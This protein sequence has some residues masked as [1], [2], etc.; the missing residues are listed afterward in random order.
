MSQHKKILKEAQSVLSVL[1]HAKDDDG[2]RLDV[3]M[4]EIYLTDKNTGD[5]LELEIGLDEEKTKKKGNGRTY[6]KS[7][8]KSELAAEEL[9]VIY[10]E[11]GV[12]GEPVE[13][14]W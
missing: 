5:V 8:H 3:C 1:K 10:D 7:V 6:Y 11:R 9:E 2:N 14:R 13:Y 12:G 4:C